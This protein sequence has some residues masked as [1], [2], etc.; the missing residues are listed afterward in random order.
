MKGWLPERG[1]QLRG[2]V[3]S[4]FLCRCHGLSRLGLAPRILDPL[5]LHLRRH[6]RP[7]H[8]RISGIPTVPHRPQHDPETEGAPQ[9]HRRCWDVRV[10]WYEPFEQPVHH[11]RWRRSRT[12]RVRGATPPPSLGA[13]VW[14]SHRCP[15][16]P[17]RTFQ[18]PT[19]E[20]CHH[21]SHGQ[22]HPKRLDDGQDH[23][24]ILSANLL[25]S[26]F[27]RIFIGARHPQRSLFRMGPPG[28]C[29][30]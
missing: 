29:L 11:Q 30:P 12:R 20:P 14:P 21:E 15:S 13:R 9:D 3:S 25:R 18:R 4:C 19:V 26:R 8:E 24:G 28:A 6:G 2:G 27:Q 7:W 10:A 23:D 17:W 22:Q 16:G 5:Q 1:R